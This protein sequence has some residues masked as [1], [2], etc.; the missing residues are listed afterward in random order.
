MVLIHGAQITRDEWEFN[1]EVQLLASRGYLAFLFNPASPPRHA[2]EIDVPVL[3]MLGEEDV[4][5]PIS[6]S[7]KMRD[8]L[9]QH[10]T[11][12]T[13]V[14]LPEEGHGRTYIPS[15]TRYYTKLLD[16]LNQHIG[17]GFRQKAETPQASR[18]S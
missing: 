18:I 13:W 3:P 1:E 14:S 5:V 9:E 16:F 4:R 11:L 6:N 8:A 15:L 12:V 10:K 17:P 2:D 7:Q